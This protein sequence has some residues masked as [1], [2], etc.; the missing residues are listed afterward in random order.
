MRGFVTD[1]GSTK[2]RDQ[3]RLVRNWKREWNGQG[4]N[5]PKKGETFIRGSGLKTAF[6]EGW[7]SRAREHHRNSVSVKQ[8]SYEM[9]Q[10]GGG[11]K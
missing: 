2:R 6:R 4:K 1:D 9:L 3:T 8:L 10:R 5:K 7:V 11:S